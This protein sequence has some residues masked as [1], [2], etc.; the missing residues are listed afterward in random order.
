MAS[1]NLEERQKLEYNTERDHLVLPEYGRHL[2]RLANSIKKL[3]DPEEQKVYIERTIDM[4]IQLF[5][6][7]KSVDNYRE[8]LWHDIFYM[9]GF[10]FKVLPPNGE[11]PTFEDQMLRPEQ[12]P[13]PVHHLQ[14][15]HYG[16]NV[17]L[18]IQKAL[19]MEDGPVKKEFVDVIG[20]YMKLAYKTWNKE[21][22]VSDDMI[23]QDLSAMTKGE[24]NIDS[25]KDLDVL[26]A[27][28]VK[29]RFLPAVNQ[30]SNNWKQNKRKPPMKNKDRRSKY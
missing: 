3:E 19:A 15:K 10:E 12:V 7:S 27:S 1:R 14:Y 9:A 21:H 29:K 23:R 17:Y 2:Q 5:P 13:Y 30:N 25:E 20:A 28:Q 4:I 16:Y 24:L 8:K 18:M 6:E 11:R 26:V 22:F